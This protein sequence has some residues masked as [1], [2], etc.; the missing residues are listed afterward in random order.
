VL[1]KSGRTNDEALT[2]VLDTLVAWIDALT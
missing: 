2:E 1:K